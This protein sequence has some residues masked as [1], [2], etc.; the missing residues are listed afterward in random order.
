MREFFIDFFTDYGRFIV[1]LHIISAVIWIG[2]MIVVKFVVAPSMAK[3]TDVKIRLS[4]ILEVMQRLL[5]FAM[6]FMILLAITGTFMSLGLD[7]KHSSPSLYILIHIK[8]AVWTLM[9]LNFIYIYRK[10]NSAQ[11]QF[12]KGDLESCSESIFTISNYLL[13]LNIFLGF[14]AI[15]FGVILRGL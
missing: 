6:I 8:E 1:F 12:L 2:G 7:F 11:R 5:N 3:I 15:Y 9:T 14:V 13:P 10:R 4:R